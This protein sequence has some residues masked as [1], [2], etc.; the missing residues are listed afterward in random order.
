MAFHARVERGEANPLHMHRERFQATFAQCGAVWQDDYLTFYREQLIQTCTP[1]AGAHE[2]LGAL[3]PRFNLALLTNAYDGEEQRLRLRQSGL[4]AYFQAVV[5]S[6]EVGSYKPQPEV[7]WHT[8]GLL[9]V[10][11]DEALYVGDSPHH[12]VAG[13]VAAGMQA[14]LIRPGPAHPDAWLTVPTLEALAR[15]WSEAEA[16]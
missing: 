13:A 9:G 4:E 10:R 2:L 7:F 15:L 1:L 11:P 6:G 8:L 12:D 5:V 14:V 3:R 16:S